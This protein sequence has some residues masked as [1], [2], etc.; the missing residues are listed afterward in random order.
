[1]TDETITYELIRKMQR[2][3]QNL[4]K[5][6]KLPENFFNAVSG[7]LNHKRSLMERDSR[8]DFL[9]VKNV[10]RLIEDI[11][12][13]RERKAMNAAIVYARTKIHP[14]NLLEEEKL[15]F[16]SMVAL[17]KGRR[18]GL[19]EHIIS[20]SGEASNMFVF[21]EDAPEFVGSDMKIYGPYKKGDTANLPMDNAKV[22]LEKG[23][24]EEFKLQK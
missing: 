19:L 21:K 4:P 6:S 15:F 18:D 12:N 10:E 20:G 14:E 3:E 13:R 16:N 1:M 23:M 8:K 5:L 11:L 9:E 17:I 2:E 7:Y 24:V 22:L